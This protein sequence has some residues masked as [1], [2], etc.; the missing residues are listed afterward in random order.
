VHIEYLAVSE[1]YQRR[2]LG[3]MMMYRALATFRK[4][5]EEIGAPV[6]TLV[7]LKEEL[8]KYYSDL[9]FL[10]YAQH[11]KERIMMLTAAQAIGA[12]KKSLTE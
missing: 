6:L 1:E 2:K 7:P 4:A 8:V 10:R 5:V 3:T 12:D 11:L 9:G